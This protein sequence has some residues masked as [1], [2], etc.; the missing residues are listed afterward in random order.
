MYERILNKCWPSSPFTKIT[1]LHSITIFFRP[2]WDEKFKPLPCSSARWRGPRHP[3]WWCQRSFRKR[4]MGRR[5]TTAGDP[6]NIPCPQPRYRDRCEWRHRGWQRHSRT[7]RARVFMQACLTLFQP[8]FVA[9]GTSELLL[10]IH[11]DVHFTAPSAGWA[12]YIS[13]VS[14]NPADFA[15]IPSTKMSFLL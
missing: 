1:M 14:T 3:Q 7:H 11:S 8:I 6:R 4:R 5:W 10:S 9:I 12:D 2:N 13:L 15:E